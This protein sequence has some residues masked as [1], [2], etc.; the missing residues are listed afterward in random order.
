[1]H[2]IPLTPASLTNGLFAHRASLPR[3]AACLYLLTSSQVIGLLA[4][5]H[6]TVTVVYYYNPFIRASVRLP[7]RPVGKH[8]RHLL[9]LTSV[10]DTS[11]MS[12]E[13][14][15]ALLAVAWNIW[16][17]SDPC[18]SPLFIRNIPFDC[19]IEKRNPKINLKVSTTF[20]PHVSI[21]PPVL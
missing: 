9:F 7:P 14:K 20:L 16:P 12:I 17:L 5:T 8:R 18:R 19:G 15:I 13:T 3:C 2:I 21:C 10:L 11:S 6:P 4:I 1:M